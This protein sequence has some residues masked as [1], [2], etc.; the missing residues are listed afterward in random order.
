MMCSFLLS[1]KIASMLIRKV[2]TNP[3]FRPFRSCLLDLF[4]TGEKLAR[5]LPNCDDLVGDDG[6]A[7]SE[8][9]PLINS[10]TWSIEY[11]A[12]SYSTKILPDL[13]LTVTLLIPF[14]CFN[15]D[16][17]EGLKD[18]PAIALLRNLTLPGVALT[19]I[20]FN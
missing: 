20:C 19:S 10:S 9:D 4:P 8:S 2:A 6:T 15:W 5:R 13:V 16:S 12:V 7:G 17:T 3:L 18:D 14:F 11:T 1:P